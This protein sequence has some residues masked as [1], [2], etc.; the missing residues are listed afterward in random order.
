[1]TYEEAIATQDAI[2][3]ID[4]KRAALRK[5]SAAAAKA[6]MAAMDF[7]AALTAV[8]LDSLGATDSAGTD[9]RT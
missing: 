4:E 8:S 6:T 7:S 1:M 2:E 5:L 3:R 9:P